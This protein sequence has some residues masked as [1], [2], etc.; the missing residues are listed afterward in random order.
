ME[1]F[2][3]N[4]EVKVCLMRSDWTLAL[5]VRHIMGQPTGILA[6]AWCEVEITPTLHLL[7][8]PN[9]S[10]SSLELMFPPDVM[11]ERGQG[12]MLNV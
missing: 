8:I 2:A 11:A 6:Q 3:F 4:T 12:I 9:P 7:T 1:N 5:G 10:K